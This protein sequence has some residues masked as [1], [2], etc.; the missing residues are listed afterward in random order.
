M[1][2]RL[3]FYDGLCYNNKDSCFYIDVIQNKIF[4]KIK[5]NFKINVT[6]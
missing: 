1:R 3:F 4:R 6:F 5:K 2:S